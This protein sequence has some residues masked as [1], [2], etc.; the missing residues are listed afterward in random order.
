MGSIRLE[1]EVRGPG[2][3]LTVGQVRRSNHHSQYSGNFGDRQDQSRASLLEDLG[4]GGK[5]NKRQKK[6]GL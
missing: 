1:T 4:M 6:P 3:L 2:S 5:L